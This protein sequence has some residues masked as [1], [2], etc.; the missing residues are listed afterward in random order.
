MRANLPYELSNEAIAMLVL[1]TQHLARPF[2]EKFRD[3][4]TMAQIHT[5]CQLSAKGPMTMTELSD[6]LRMPK[7]Q[8]TKIVNAL[9]DEGHIRRYHDESDRRI[10]IS[11]LSEETGRYLTAQKESYASNLSRA[12]HTLSDEDGEEL[13]EAVRRVN[14]I[15]GKLKTARNDEE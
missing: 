13:L 9:E 7:Q 12:L 8:L 5:I 4:F 14:A 11:E 1:V 15:L 2:E 3:R 10:I 6:T